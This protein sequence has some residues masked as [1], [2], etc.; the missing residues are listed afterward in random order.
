MKKRPNLSENWIAAQASIK[1]NFHLNSLTMEEL[2]AMLLSVLIRKQRI[3][4]KNQRKPYQRMGRKGRDS[5][6]NHFMLSKI[7]VHLKT[8]MNPQMKKEP[9]NFF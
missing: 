2:D 8:Q 9:L 4:L 7:A 5:I 1:V 3:R 6:E